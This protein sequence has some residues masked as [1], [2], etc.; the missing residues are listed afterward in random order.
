MK[1]R[2]TILTPVKDKEETVSKFIEGNKDILSKYKVIVVDTRGGEQL[3]KY[4]FVYVNDVEGKYAM[5]EARKLGIGLVDTEYILNLDT[6]VILP[7]H[8]I[9]ASII[10]MDNEKDIGAISIDHNKLMGHLGFGQS[11]WRTELLKELYDYNNKE[12]MCEC[13]YM[14]G[15][16]NRTNYKLETIGNLRCKH[17]KE[18]K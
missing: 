6:H 4:S 2:L 9:N 5:P 3:K 1:N 13:C 14:W 11:I 8:Y 16:L 18:K 17:L 15:K 10:L 12:T 7:K